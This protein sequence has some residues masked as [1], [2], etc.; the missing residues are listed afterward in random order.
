MSNGE[1]IKGGCLREAPDLEWEFLSEDS[2][3]HLNYQQKI[4]Y[5]EFWT[6]FL[7]FVRERGKDPDRHKRST[8]RS[9]CPSGLQPLL[10]TRQGYSGNHSHTRDR[11]PKQ[12]RQSG[13]H[14]ECGEGVHRGK[15]K[16]VQG[17]YAS[18]LPIPR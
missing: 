11:V 10:G 6:N 14:Y 18:V 4:L 16:E 2:L 15:Q 7:K 9:S 17:R 8:H 13:S 1:E 12:V 5:H 3:K